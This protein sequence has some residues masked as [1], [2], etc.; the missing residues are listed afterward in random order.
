MA[1]LDI[2]ETEQEE[3]ET[4]PINQT[5]LVEVQ[6]YDIVDSS[7]RD[8]AGN[9]RKDIKWTL[10]VLEPTEF[11]DRV[12]VFWT[13]FRA[14]R[15]KKTGEPN[16]TLKFLQYLGFDYQTQGLNRVDLDNFIGKK[17]NI[18]LK[19]KFGVGGRTFQKVDNFFPAIAKE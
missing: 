7:F 8:K 1:E 13:P 4:L 19:N 16:K 9:F 2:E 17:I 10:R 12:L 15:H 6:S 18:T 11:Y 5:Y 14:S 3:Y